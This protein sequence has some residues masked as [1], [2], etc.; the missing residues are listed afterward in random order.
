MKKMESVLMV[1]IV[2][3]TFGIA[4]C[5]TTPSPT[6]PEMVS[7]ESPLILVSFREGEEIEGNDESFW[8]EA[9]ETL[10][11]QVWGMSSLTYLESGDDLQRLMESNTIFLVRPKDL[12]YLQDLEVKYPNL[13]PFSCSKLESYSF[14]LFYFSR[15]VQTDRIRGVI[16]A[17]KVSPSLAEILF[18]KELP[19]DTFLWYEDGQLQ[20]LNE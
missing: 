4:G 19:L 3:L 1:I 15:N 5:G 16:I 8:G 2:S 7:L 11:M 18:K 14:P 6:P 17:D 10:H 9:V 20:I 12:K 13:L